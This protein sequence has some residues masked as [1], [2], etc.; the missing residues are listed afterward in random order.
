MTRNRPSAHMPLAFSYLRFSNPEQGKGDSVRRQNELRDAFLAES[1]AVLD[2]S[3]T[4]RDEGVSAYTGAH[5]KNPDRHALAAFL[6]LVRRDRVPR[7]S[8]FI[9]ESL[10]RLTREHI[11]P[12]LTLLLNLIESGVRVVQLL[13]VKAVYDEDVEP[14]A[15]MM[16]IM[17]LSRG[18][19]ES[20]M[21]SERVGAA[22]REKK[23][24]AAVEKAPITSRVP[25]W[26]RVAR[27]RF[28]VDEEKAAAV[29][30]VYREAAAGYGLGLIVKRLNAEG[31][32]PI[33]RATYWARSYVAKLLS[34]RAVLGEYQP[35]TRRGGK[36]VPEGKP[37]PGYFPAI[38]TEDEWH[39]A[40]AALRARRNKGGRPGGRVNLF[41]NLLRDARDGGSLHQVN[42]GKK[43]SGPALVNYKAALG[44][45]GTKYV[46]FPLE[47][48]EEKVLSKLREIDPREVLPAGNGDAERV[49]VLAGKLG[50]VEGRI[51]KVKAQLVE[52]GDLAPLVDVLRALEAKRAATAEDL[53]EA[54]RKAASPLSGAWG[55]CRSL[56]DA[57]DTAPDR[58]DARVRLRSAIRRVVEG[59]W[60]LFVARGCVRLAA[61]QVWFAGGAHRDYLILHRPAAGGAVPARRPRS[62]VCSTADVVALGELDLRKRAHAREL[63]RELLAVDLDD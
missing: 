23:R 32:P 47:V 57:L 53:A 58:E 15:L 35:H 52:G 27:G 20:R 63:E 43:G 62:E 26:L 40:R 41:A 22:W 12:A 36:R 28:V 55:E 9:I 30:R 61:V 21:K 2:T 51:E 54:R 18:H 10:D 39:A 38:V 19:S 49:M 11:R 24:S 5:R 50:D 31:V 25:A 6:E 17:E 14:M 1:G 46:G 13:P 29:R 37:I 16:A 48:F 45:K 42:K 8:Y 3:L 34:N 4:L 33:G 44:V 59:V 56:L 60:C 7:G